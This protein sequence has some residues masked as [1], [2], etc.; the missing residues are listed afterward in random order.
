MVEVLAE[1]VVV[2]EE[3]DDDEDDDEEDDDED[4]D[5]FA[6]TWVILGLVRPLKAAAVFPFT[7]ALRAAKAVPSG[8]ASAAA[9]DKGLAWYD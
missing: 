8:P 1:D 6:A 3:D 7:E 9:C 5:P 2:V 4:E